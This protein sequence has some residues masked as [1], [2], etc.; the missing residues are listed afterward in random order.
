MTKATNSYKGQYL[1]VAALQVQRFSLSLSRQK[2]GTMVE[3][4]RGLHLHLEAA[5]TGFQAARLRVLKP[6]TLSRTVTHLL[7]QG[8]T[9]NSATPWTKCL[10]SIT[11]EKPKNHTNGVHKRAELWL[12]HLHTH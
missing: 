8:P 7:Q 10:Q 6:R 1:V 11:L 3:E 4:L 12:R 5:K 9:T 2:H